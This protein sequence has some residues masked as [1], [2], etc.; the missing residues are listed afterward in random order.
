MS[1]RFGPTEI[2]DLLIAY[3]VLTVAF[4]IVFS[5]GVLGGMSP[6]SLTAEPFIV[7]AI[8]VGTG[9][10]LHELA[11]KFVAQ[12]YGYRAE[13]KV[14][15]QGLFLTIITS[16]M[17]FIFAM[18]GAVVISGRA[19]NPGSQWD[20]GQGAAQ[21]DEYWDRM[22]RNGKVNRP[23]LFISIA[24]VITNILIAAFF[25]FLLRERLVNGLLMEAAYTG[26]LINIVLAA[27]NMIPFGPLDGAKV[28]KANPLIWAIVGLP[29]IL[30]W[31]LL[32]TGNAGLVLG[33]LLGY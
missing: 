19:Y 30:F 21:D 24:G 1:P 33:P 2:T 5:G 3:I 26:L 25:L 31:L 16:L 13:F 12:R 14:S 6:S 15:M 10:L 17:G 20:Y 4:G 8:G 29:L 23:E 11:H 32:F 7:S 9:F 28:L 27:F 22:S 18:P